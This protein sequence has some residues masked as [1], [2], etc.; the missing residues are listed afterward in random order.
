[1]PKR[2]KTKNKNST[3]A[4][5]A[6]KG[7]N[8]WGGK[9][10]G[11]GRKNN[12]GEVSHE[13]RE[14][15]DYRKPLHLTLKLKDKRWNLRCGEMSAA[16]KSSAVGA[17]TFGLKILHYS[18][19]KDHLHILVEARDNDQLT[20]GMR[21]FGA[22]FGKAIR[23]IVGGRGSVFKGRFHLQ[24]ITNPTQM[25][26]A[27]TYVLENFSKHSRVLRHIDPYSSAAY[28]HQW[29]KLL[30]RRAGPILDELNSDLSKIFANKRN[31]PSR[32]SQLERESQTLH[33]RLPDYLSP[34]RSWLAREG[35]LRAKALT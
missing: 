20:R 6:F 19:L 34:P 18:L 14:K 31:S 4:Q 15:V 8:G 16:F 2:S 11:A 35:W 22:R 13:K 12:S 23:K 27:L 21:S 3:A 28:F 5:A 26:N 32:G 9:R 25:R 10:R 33:H 7:V 30:G 17:K 29:P 1:M 24:V